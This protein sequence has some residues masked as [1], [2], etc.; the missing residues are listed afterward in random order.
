V[1]EVRRQR[2]DG[3]MTLPTTLQL[4]IATN[5][6]LRAEDPGVQRAVGLAGADPAAVFA[7]LRERK[8]RA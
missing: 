4:E 6:F 2:E 1:E 5:P 7:E 3:R 8:N